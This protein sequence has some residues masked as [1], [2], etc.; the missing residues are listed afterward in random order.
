M[1]VKMNAVSTKPNASAVS[2]LIAKRGFKRS[3]ESTTRIA[4]YHLFSEGYKVESGSSSVL[5]RYVKGD[6]SQKDPDANSRRDAN[7][8]EIAALLTDKGF[9]VTVSMLQP[10]LILVKKA[11]A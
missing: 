6:W 11:V 3:V 9:D 8:K 7:M 4:G 10:D 2:R 5:V 1:G